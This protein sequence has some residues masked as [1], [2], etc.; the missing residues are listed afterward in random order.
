M[1]VLQQGKA[2]GW[3]VWNNAFAPKDLGF[4]ARKH[5]SFSDFAINGLTASS[6]YRRQQYFKPVDFNAAGRPSKYLLVFNDIR[7]FKISD[8]ELGL[9]YSEFDGMRDRDGYSFE[10][11]GLGGHP[12][13]TLVCC[14]E[15]ANRQDAQKAAEELLAMKFTR[16]P[17]SL[18]RFFLENTSAH[19]RVNI[20]A[21]HLESGTIFSVMWHFGRPIDDDTIGE[22]G[23]SNFRAAISLACRKMGWELQD[24][25]SR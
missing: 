17:S 4:D 9:G 13:L 8:S 3:D 20:E 14:D 2:M 22:I 18:K 19:H 1:Q 15:F 25:E 10:I 11:L 24:K 12:D 21:D 5:G 23:I 7:I 16:L 6:K